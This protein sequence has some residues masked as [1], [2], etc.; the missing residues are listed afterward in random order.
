MRGGGF[1]PPAMIAPRTRP[2]DERVEKGLEGVRV[3][4]CGGGFAASSTGKILADLGAQV[5]KVEPPGGDPMRREE[6]AH[7]AREGAGG[8]FLHL[9]T[10]KRSVVLD[11]T[12][13]RDAA[14]FEGLVRRADLLVREGGS[15]SAL[16]DAEEWRRRNPRLVVVSITPFGCF[17]PRRNWRGTDLT[18]VHAGGWGYIIPG[19]GAPREWPP[20]RP[21]GHH[22]LVQ[23]GVHAAVPALAACRAARATG[24]GDHLDV[25][26]QETVAFMLGRHYTSW[27]YLGRIDHRSDGSIYEPM[28]FYR[29]RDGEVFIICPEQHQWERLLE[30]MGASEWGACEAFGSRDGRGAR[31]AEIRERVSAWTAERSSEEIFHALQ[32]VRVGAAPVFDY[33]RLSVQEHLR[34]REFF[35]PL[36]HPGLGRIEML[37]PPYRLRRRWWRLARPAPALDEAA[38]EVDALFTAGTAGGGGRAPVKTPESAG[39]DHHPGS[40]GGEQGGARARSP[41]TGGLAGGDGGGVPDGPLRGVRV[42]D[43]SWVWAGPHCTMML[44]ALGAEVL[45]VESSTRLDLTRRASIFARDLPP[46][47]NRNGYFNQIGQ[48]KKSVGID[49]AKD[50]GRSL[51]KRLAAQCDAFVANFGTGVLERMGLGPEELL[52]INPRLVVAL[53]SAFGQEG[54]WRL[55][56]GYGPLISPLSGLSAQTGYP[57]DGRPRDVNMAYGDPNGGVYAAVAVTASLLARD[58]HGEDGQVAD[59][60]MWEAMACTSFEGWMNHVLGGA[61][62]RVMGNRAPAHAPCNVYRCHGEDA[63]VAVEAA[64]DDEWEALCGALGRPSLAS[65]P[66]FSSP[67]ARKANEDDLDRIIAKWCATRDRWAV[68]ETLQAVG[69]PAFPSASN[70]DLRADPHL[71]ARGAFH[72]FEHPEVGV[73]AHLRVPWCWA[74]RE[75]GT[76]R[77]A[78]CLGEHTD[79]VLGGVLG[80]SKD[81]LE[82][83]RARRVIE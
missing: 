24:K 78:P 13:E 83:L 26:V 10:N 30:V 56:T 75:N 82:H 80:I 58:L 55:Y 45:K 4:E 36:D 73:R 15:A 48:H 21:F 39:S 7:C 38:D 50:E 51:V 69:V 81:E 5:V 60:A 46:G 6:P 42:L 64:A 62:Y 63:W 47:P 33:P 49:L 53:V 52:A 2:G 19:R 34:A 59:V 31:A 65:D 41:M 3:I 23:A 1:G 68:S 54:P 77:R 11:R 28:G 70:A 72:A 25:S 9:N 32:S 29:C 44:G 17:G 22:A 67:G 14:A 40:P 61:P 74:D 79:E 12:V 71:A 43:L 66:R 20:L 76:G 35:V 27:E 18:L 8:P 37:G 16:D 57:E